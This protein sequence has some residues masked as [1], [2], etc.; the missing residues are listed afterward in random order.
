MKHCEQC[1]KEFEP[2]TENREKQR[3]CSVNCSAAWHYRQGRK[4]TCV[5]QHCGK[6]FRPKA[7]D[8]TTFCSRDCAYAHRKAHAKGR[9]PYKRKLPEQSYCK[10]CGKAL[11]NPTAKTCDDPECQARRQQEHYWRRHP[12]RKPGKA[13]ICKECGKEFIKEYGNKHRVYCSDECLRRRGRRIGKARR[14]ARI[15]NAEHESID[16]RDVFERDGWI[17]GICG[18]KVSRRLKYPHPRS[19]SL[20]HIRPLAE[21]GTHTLGNVQCSHLACNLNKGA[22]GGG[23]LRLG[24]SLA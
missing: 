3:F 8:R 1:G 15:R 23:Q 22:S 2:E 18:T 16:P 11:D 10:F 12:D 14:R 17:C 21:G 9:Q 4:T 19:A 13:F 5:C 6:E 20:D 7:K 24:L